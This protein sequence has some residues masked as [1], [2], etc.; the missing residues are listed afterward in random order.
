MIIA[1]FNSNKTQIICLRFVA[2][3]LFSLFLFPSLKSQTSTITI[4]KDSVI[5]AIWNNASSSVAYGKK[6]AKGYYKIFISDTLGNNEIPL[7]FSAWKNDRHQ[8]PEEWHPSGKYLFCYIE[9][10][11]YLKEKE[12]RRAPIDAIPGYGAYTDLWLISKDG[13][14]AWQLTDLPNKYSS[15]IIHSAISEDGK[16][17]AWSERIAVPKFTSKN[18]AAGSYVI[19]VADFT[20]DSVPKLTNIRTYQPGNVAA[21]N[22]LESFSKDNNYLLF[23]SSFETKN[24]INTPIY[25]LNLKNGEIQKLTSESFAQA[26]TY[27][28]DGN[29][30]IYMTGKDCDIFPMQLQGADWWIMDI[31]GNNKQR[32][33]YM[34]KWNHKQSVNRYRL[35]GSISPISNH[36]FLGG[37]MTKSLGLTG[38]TV[39][40][41]FEIPKK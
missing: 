27:T 4:W 19:K 31:D 37:V 3:T 5:G 11:E 33:T 35:A 41:T 28:P 24:I 36:S 22:E 1:Y 23:Y 29:S 14:Q 17:F 7:T 10:P 39:K 6:D 40:V 16:L 8:W 12:H 2:I 21:L 30:I 32:L 20:F 9:K 13:T 25:K 15:G 18:L 26:P 34:N 38:Y